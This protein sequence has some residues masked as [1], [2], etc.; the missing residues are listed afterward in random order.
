MVMRIEPIAEALSSLGFQKGT[1][2]ER[3]IL[4]SAKGVLFTQ[5]HAQ[6][7]SSSTQRILFICGHY[8]GVDERVAEHLVDAE[9]RIGNYVL[10]GGELPALVMA[11]A[12][13]RLL[14]GVLGAQASLQEESHTTPGYLEYPHYT[15]PAEFRGWKVPEVLQQGNHA[16]I[17]KWRASHAAMQSPDR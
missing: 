2:E 9:V 11:D 3:I 5:Q 7:W 16:E 15:R 10:T 12:V 6:E 8:E 1:P 17:M 13:T 14:P 4:T